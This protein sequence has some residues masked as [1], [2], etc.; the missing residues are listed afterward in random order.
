[1][2][3]YG[4][5]VSPQ[6]TIGS[7]TYLVNITLETGEYLRIDSRSRT[8]VKVLKNGEEMNEYHCRSKGR[9]FFQKIQPGRQMI[10]W[11]GKFNFDLTVYEER[12]EPKWN[13]HQAH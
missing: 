3:I 9:E 2:I 13:V 4:P 6:V 11:T 12:S 7:N 10:Q 1:M 8:I 5:V